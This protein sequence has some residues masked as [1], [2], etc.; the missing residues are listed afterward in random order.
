MVTIDNPKVSAY[1][2][3]SLQLLVSLIAA[4]PLTVLHLA[5]DIYVLIRR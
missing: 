3:V 2:S 4:T 1:Q 5:K